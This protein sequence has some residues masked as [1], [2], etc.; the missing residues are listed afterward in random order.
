MEHY[1]R[2]PN[3]VGYVLAESTFDL[4]ECIDSTWAAAFAEPYS[5]TSP[6]CTFGQIPDVVGCP[7][8]I[9]F[10][11]AKQTGSIL[12]CTDGAMAQIVCPVQVHGETVAALLFGPKQF[13]VEYTPR[14]RE[15]IK[16]SAAHLAF[17]LG[18]E[19]LAAKVARQI[20]RRLRMKRELGSAREVQDRLFAYRLPSI[21]GL[22]YYGE[23]WPI[24]E[25]GGDFFD[26]AEC[27][28]SSLS[29]TIGDVSGKGAPAAITM[30]AALGSLKALGSDS[31]G[32]PWSCRVF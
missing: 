12:E 22:D 13:G 10:A 5:N 3:A 2:L 11:H 17:I 16:R 21:P 31:E 1:S 20:A 8:H 28:N 32:R 14:D 9:P 19:Q 23:C 15:L 24:G 4:A 27:H 26:F 30:A 7:A 6:L 29:I 18:D 25:L